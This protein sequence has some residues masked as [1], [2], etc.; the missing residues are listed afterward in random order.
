MGYAMGHLKQE[1]T[2]V[3]AP[4][5]SPHS[6][7]PAST[8]INTPHEEYAN[9]LAER[10]NEAAQH[11]QRERAL[12]NARLAVF[13]LGL[14]MAWLAWHEGLFSGWFLL[15]PILAF[16]VLASRHDRVIRAAQTGRARNRFLRKRFAPSG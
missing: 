16:V 7:P 11:A 12:S 10:K 5:L 6:T 4:I 13:A 15:L 1:A 9:R 3:H 14:L 8:P 2:T